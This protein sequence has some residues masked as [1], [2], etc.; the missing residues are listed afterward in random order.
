MVFKI[1]LFENSISFTILKIPCIYAH[2]RT[3]S[4]NLKI[5][6]CPKVH[7]ILHSVHIMEWEKQ[8]F[9]I[10]WNTLKKSL[11]LCLFVAGTN[12]ISYIQI[13][14]LSISVPTPAQLE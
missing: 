3:K 14:I 9:V 1:N 7:I 8:Q 12:M 5:H 6:L 4:E 13:H 11:R 10:I 2:F